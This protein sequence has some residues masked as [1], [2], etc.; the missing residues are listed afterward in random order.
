[1]RPLL[2]GSLPAL[3]SSRAVAPGELPSLTRDFD[4]LLKV[5]PNTRCTRRPQ[6]QT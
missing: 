6:V 3:L 2:Y 4:L 1:V 5:L